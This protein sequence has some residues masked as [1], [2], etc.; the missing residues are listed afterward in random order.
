MHLIFIATTICTI[1]IQFLEHLYYSFLHDKHLQPVHL[2]FMGTTVWI[3][4]VST[5]ESLGD[6]TG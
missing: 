1:L 3:H 4:A 5:A 6:V 2:D